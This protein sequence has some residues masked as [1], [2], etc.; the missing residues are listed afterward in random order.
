MTIAKNAA[1]FMIQAS[2]PEGSPIEGLPPT[3][4][5]VPGL[6]GEMKNHRPISNW[7]GPMIS[8]V[9]FIHAWEKEM[10]NHVPVFLEV[11][12]AEN[13]EISVKAFEN[14]FIANH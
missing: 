1:D 5:C 13:Y 9:S 6:H 10:L 3:Y 8:Y 4:Y 7:F 2:A 12:G 11:K 14:S